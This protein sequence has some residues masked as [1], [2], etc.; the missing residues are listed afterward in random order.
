MN[1]HDATWKE[2]LGNRQELS[3]A[4]VSVVVFVITILSYTTF[5]AAI[6]QR[7]GVVF[8]DPIHLMVGPVDLTWF[9]FIALYGALLLAIYGMMHTPLILL[10]ALRAYT[11]LVAI[12]MIAMWV[13][14]LDPPATMIPLADPIVTTF[15]NG[16]M[17]TLT[18]DLFF[19]GHTATLCLIGFIIPIR[20]MRWVFLIL[21]VLVGAAVV[22][23]HV[24]YTVDVVIAPFAALGAAAL[25]GTMRSRP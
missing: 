6:E 7:Q 18:R 10:R 5:L 4:V 9:I 21:A 20:W 13:M 12:R 14:P 22:V 1:T 25:T 23:Q 8:T 15:V 3:V 24:H 16:G 17:A 11:L 19:S 2:V